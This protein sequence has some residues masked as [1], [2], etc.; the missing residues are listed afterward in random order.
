MSMAGALGDGGVTP[1]MLSAAREHLSHATGDVATD[2]QIALGYL[3]VTRAL[4]VPCW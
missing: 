1:E 2:N 4:T 3:Q